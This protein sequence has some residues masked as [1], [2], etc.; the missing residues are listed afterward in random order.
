MSEPSQI[1]FSYKEVAEALVKKHGLHE[2]IWTLAI[3]FGLQATNMGPNDSELKPVVMNA[4]LGIGLQRAEK[5]TNLS[6]NA[7]VVNPPPLISHTR[8]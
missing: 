2:G 6:V 3:N 5:E 8:H 4:I 1:M 7:A